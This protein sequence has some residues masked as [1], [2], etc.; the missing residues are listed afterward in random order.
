MSIQLIYEANTAISTPNT[1]HIMHEETIH[2]NG[3]PINKVVF[4]A[5]LQTCNEVNGNRRW[6]SKAFCQEIVKALSPVAKNRSLY[7]EVD[8]P[9][10][11]D[12]NSLAAKAR[13]SNT[14]LANSG[15]MI[16]DIYMDGNDIVGHIETLSGF[17]GP[18]LSNLISIDKANIGFSARLFADSRPHP[19]RKGVIEVV[20]PFKA[21]TYDVVSN[22]SHTTSRIIELVSESSDGTMHLESDI[23][24]IM[25]ADRKSVQYTDSSITLEGFDLA[26]QASNSVDATMSNYSESDLRFLAEHNLAPDTRNVLR[27][28]FEEKLASEFVAI[29]HDANLLTI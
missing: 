4:K 26:A 15:A 27:E 29:G 24:A 6:Y 25:M 8:H 7:M 5:V 22:P 1:R 20:G 2:L 14:I 9:I 18:D 11:S 12:P 21:V 19:S 28:Y 16:R 17:R 10:L 13:A 23:K 3:Q